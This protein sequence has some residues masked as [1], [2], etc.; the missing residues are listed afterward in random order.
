M[1]KKLIHIPLF[2]S[3]EQSSNSNWSTASCTKTRIDLSTYLRY[4]LARGRRMDQGRPSSLAPQR[5][6]RPARPPPSFAVAS[7]PRE[8]AAA[9]EEAAEAA[10]VAK[11][12]RAGTVA[13][14]ATTSPA[15]ATAAVAWVAL[16]AI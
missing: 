6:G 7:V 4:R 3:F 10:T 11:L 8:A 1:D 5:P 15:A 2:L 9:T 16:E 14:A 12:E 13:A